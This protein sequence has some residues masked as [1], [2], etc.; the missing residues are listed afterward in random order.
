MLI[1]LLLLIV[2][3]FFVPYGVDLAFADGVFRLG[4]RAGPFRIG[5]YPPSPLIQKLL[6]KK[7]KGK[8]PK[9]EPEQSEEAPKPE[10]LDKTEK[11]PKKR[12]WDLDTI[13]ALLKMGIHA[14]RRFFRSFT[15][16]FFQLHLLLASNDP[17]T[18]A[19]EYAAA[20]SAVEALPAMCADAIRVRRRD[21]QIGSDFLTEKPQIKLRLVLTLQL[22]RLVHLAVALAAEFIAWKIKTRRANAA[23]ASERKADNG[24]HKVQ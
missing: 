16:D 24:R 2:L 12:E 4:V 20:C 17:Y 1:L 15:V 11:I 21:I 9:Q 6:S 7:Q 23:A 10:P 22:F 13:L 3:I 14:V 18:T 5:L 19:M 8:K